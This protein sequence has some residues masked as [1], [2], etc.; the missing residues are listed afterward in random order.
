MNRFQSLA[1]RSLLAQ[2]IYFSQPRSASSNLGMTLLSAGLLLTTLS[3]CLLPVISSAAT[4]APP[5]IATPAAYMAPGANRRVFQQSLP[6]Y[7]WHHDCPLANA[8]SLRNPNVT[9]KKHTY[10]TQNEALV[11]ALTPCP[12]CS[13]LE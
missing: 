4:S 12:F 8:H 9:I 5:E 10:M 1:R 11:K 2:E 13:D 3:A 6:T 7:H